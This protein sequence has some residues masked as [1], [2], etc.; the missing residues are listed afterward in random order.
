MSIVISHR[1]RL[2]RLIK[3]LAYLAT[4]GAPHNLARRRN[5][6]IVVII[7]AMVAHAILV[8]EYRFRFSVGKVN[9]L[10]TDFLAFFLGEFH[11]ESPIF[12]VLAVVPGRIDLGMQLARRIKMPYASAHTV[13]VHDFDFQ[14]T[15]WIIVP[16]GT[17]P[18]KH[19]L[20]LPRTTDQSQEKQQKEHISKNKKHLEAQPFPLNYKNFSFFI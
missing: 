18:L 11:R 12:K 14:R 16:G 10:V 1:L 19:R 2:A 6:S 15:V 9:L 13:L 5:R 20:V 3:C 17:I 8:L 7:I 4:L